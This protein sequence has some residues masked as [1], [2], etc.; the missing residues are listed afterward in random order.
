MDKKIPI[1]AQ[2]RQSFRLLRL[3]LALNSH[4]GEV[5]IIYRSHST[6]RQFIFDARQEST[7]PAAIRTKATSTSRQ[8][9]KPEPANASDNP[10]ILQKYQPSLHVLKSLNYNSRRARR[11]TQATTLAFGRFISR[12]FIFIWILSGISSIFVTFICAQSTHLIREKKYPSHL[13][14]NTAVSLWRC[15]V[16]QSSMLEPTLFLKA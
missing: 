13:N 5:F 4:Y 1:K 16:E 10:R 2:R 12:S 7:I 14:F 6:Q 9:A 8:S 15:P 3:I 11:E